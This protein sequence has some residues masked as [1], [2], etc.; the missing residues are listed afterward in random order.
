MRE[1]RGSLFMEVQHFTP[2]DLRCSLCPTPDNMSMCGLPILPADNKT[3]FFVNTVWSLLFFTN[4][5]PIALF[6]SN[7]TWNKNVWILMPSLSVLL[8]KRPPYKHT[9]QAFIPI[10]KMI[11]TS[12]QSASTSW[13][14][15]TSE[16]PHQPA[17]YGDLCLNRVHCICTLQP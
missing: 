5:I 4:S 11:R 14:C 3:S 15:N 2:N 13:Q 7:N 10:E 9:E 6:S 1:V 16:N 8:D 12:M 17:T